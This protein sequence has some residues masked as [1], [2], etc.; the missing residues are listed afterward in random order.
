MTKGKHKDK[1]NDTAEKKEGANLEMSGSCHM[2]TD[3]KTKLFGLN[4]YSFQ[5]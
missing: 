1:N 3:F 4:G 5:I 2:Q